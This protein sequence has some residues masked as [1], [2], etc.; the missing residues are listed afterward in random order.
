[1]FYLYYSCRQGELGII[2]G[3]VGVGGWGGEVRCSAGLV[4]VDAVTKYITDK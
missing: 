4:I 2:G 3:R 1:M